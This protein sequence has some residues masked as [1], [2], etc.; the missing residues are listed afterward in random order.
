MMSSCT[1]VAVW[2]NSMTDG[3]QH[4]PLAGVAGHARRHQ[5]HRR[6]D[7]FAAAVLDVVADRRDERDLR[8]DVPR[9]LALDLLADRSR[10][11]SKICASAAADGFCAV[12]FKLVR[13]D[14]IRSR[15]V[16]ARDT[17]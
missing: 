17:R 5:Q 14:H 11:G 9:E 15:S 3:V 4:R 10:I 13:S 12:G 7:A 1:S 8:L 6:A 16:N 2:M